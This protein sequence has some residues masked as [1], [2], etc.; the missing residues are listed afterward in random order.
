MAKFNIFY[1]DTSKKKQEKLNQSTKAFYNPQR[2]N[3]TVVWE[4]KEIYKCSANLDDVF[5][6]SFNGKFQPIV[7][8]LY[9]PKTKS[10]LIMWL[11]GF[12]NSSMASN[13]SEYKSIL[14]K[15]RK[16]HHWWGYKEKTIGKD[17]DPYRLTICN[18]SNVKGFY[19]LSGYVDSKIKTKKI[20]EIFNKFPCGTMYP[21]DFVESFLAGKLDFSKND[22]K[23][24]KSSFYGNNF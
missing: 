8:K 20:I 7:E 21:R 22:L 11:L 19:R 15:Q 17:D 4:G 24:I 6:I 18:M 2:K 10:E 9:I 23:F 16:L 1:I 5:K 14:K 13:L 12:S 3:F